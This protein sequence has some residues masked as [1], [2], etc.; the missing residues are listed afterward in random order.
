MDYDEASAEAEKLGIKLVKGAEVEGGDKKNVILTQDIEAGSEITKDM[1][2]IVTVSAGADTSELPNVVGKDES[3]AISTIT[4]ALPNANII[5]EYKS[6]STHSE[7]EVIS[8][9]PEGGSQ[10][11][12]SVS[13]TLTICRDSSSLNAVVPNVEGYSE[14]DAIDKINESGLSVG[15]I[16]RINS[17]SVAKGYVI[18]QTAEPGEEILKTSTIDIVVSLGRGAQTTT[19]NNTTSGG[20]TSGGNTYGG[21]TSSGGSTSSGTVNNSSS[22]PDTNEGGGTNVDD[23]VPALGS[24]EIGGTNSDSAPSETGSTETSAE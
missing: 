14:S 7:G 2:I 8:M 5:L 24:G 1:E 6:D 23:D 3:V 13:V 4:K 17:N 20:S 19:N 22:T 21:T 18:T 15:N 12:E 16:S 11:T 9:S 10:V